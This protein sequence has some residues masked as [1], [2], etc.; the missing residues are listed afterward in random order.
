MRE[1][2]N[3]TSQ[4]LINLKESPAVLKYIDI[5]QS[6]ISRMAENSA[7]CKTWCVSL[8]SALIVLSL[9]DLI[10]AEGYNEKVLWLCIGITL[11]FFFLDS[12]YL[13][14]ERKIRIKYSNFIDKLNE[15]SEDVEAQIFKF[16][17]NQWKTAR[18]FINSIGSQLLSILKGMFSVSTLFFYGLIIALLYKLMVNI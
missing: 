17:V 15:Q 18:D 1:D 8:L 16:S 12:F 5:L 14:T 2:K 6:A 11:M 13:G 7:K 3:T 9:S 10:I 4:G